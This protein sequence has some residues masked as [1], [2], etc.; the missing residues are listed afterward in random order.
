MLIRLDINRDLARARTKQNL[1]SPP[2]LLVRVAI[3]SLLSAQRPRSNAA[4]GDRL[5]RV[6]GRQLPDSYKMPGHRLDVCSG[7]VKPALLDRRQFATDKHW[8]ANCS[9]HLLIARGI[10][11]CGGSLPGHL[12]PLSEPSHPG[13]LV[14][15]PNVTDLPRLFEHGALPMFYIQQSR[16][17]LNGKAPRDGSNAHRHAMGPEQ[18]KTAPGTW[19]EPCALERITKAR[20][21]YRQI[22]ARHLLAGRS[23]FLVASKPLEVPHAFQPTKRLRQHLTY[24]WPAQQSPVEVEDNERLPRMQ[25]QPPLALT[26]TRIPDSARRRIEW[27][28]TRWPPRL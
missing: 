17:V 20:E 6:A 7:I 15:G 19:G 26:P 1:A 4:G 9:E 24:G 12:E 8:E 25:F 23:Q 2:W 14:F 13:R 10:T 21:P 22:P 11:Y 18:S 28:A 16:K 3:H 5:Q 27:P